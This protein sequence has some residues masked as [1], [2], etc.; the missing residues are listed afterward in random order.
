MKKGIWNLVLAAF[1]PVF[2]FAAILPSR[3][4]KYFIWGSAPLLN[5][6][7]WSNAL[8]EQGLHSITLMQYYF[9]IN[10][11][12][13]FDFYVEDFAPKLLPR[14]VRM[15]LGTCLALIFTLRE[16]KVVHISFNGFLLGHTP[17]WR[18]ESFLF[19]V[20]GVK[21]IVMPFGA[22]AF[23]YS[24]LMDPS[25][26]YGLLASYPKYAR[27]EDTIEKYVT[28]WTK[29]ADIVI[30]GII[31]DGMGRWDVTTN[32]I[33]AIDTAS[34]KS[35]VEYSKNNGINGSVKVLHA[36]NHTGFKGTEFVIDAVEQLKQEGLLVDL[37]LLQGVPNEKVKEVMQS[38]DIL[39]EQLIITGYALNAIEGMASGLTV[40][41]NLD[42]EAYTRVFRRYA[43][44]NECPILSTSPESV[45]GNLRLLVKNPALRNE[46]G[47]AGRKYVEKYHSSEAMQYL[48]GSIYDKIL[49]GKSVD[50]LNLFHPLKSEYNKRK[51]YIQH[52]LVENKLPSDYPLQ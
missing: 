12:D 50:L 52:P 47:Q 43:F 30:P 36:P 46:L 44:L 25:L 18:L 13:D 45:V 21:V 15:G 10:K 7:Y 1:I 28:H 49:Y 32:E 9:K 26:R 11:R 27:S 41:S 29:Y 5:N 38:A 14:V 17:F 4:R 37:I 16:A 23:M 22:D 8:R 31:I 6:K 39:I 35:K 34:W 2:F 3:A 19:R 48:F 42:Q 20:A 51:S 24:K 40:L 33:F